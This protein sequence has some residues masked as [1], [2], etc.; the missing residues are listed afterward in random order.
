MGRVKGFSAR[1]DF[2]NRRGFMY[3]GV[4]H[5]NS[6]YSMAKPFDRLTGA[7]TDLVYEGWF[8]ITKLGIP[9]NF[10]SDPMLDNIV[11]SC[12]P[13]TTTTKAPPTSTT[14]TTTTSFTLCGQES[15]TIGFF[16]FSGTHGEFALKMKVRTTQSNALLITTT[17]PNMNWYSYTEQVV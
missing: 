5:E 15:A 10:T 17:G 7:I 14:T 4:G 11:H 3:I 13:T 1:P 12:D 6:E 8:S 2:T 16:D 9:A